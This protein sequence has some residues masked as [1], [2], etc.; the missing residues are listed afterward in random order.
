MPGG[1]RAKVPRFSG[2][3]GINSSRAEHQS[4]KDVREGH[5]AQKV[6][7]LIH[8]HQAVHLWAHRGSVRGQCHAAM[9]ANEVGTENQGQQLNLT[10]GARE[11]LLETA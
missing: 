10:G 6:L 1:L 4:L 7:G 9:A 2:P 5:H 11:G 8:E 3:E